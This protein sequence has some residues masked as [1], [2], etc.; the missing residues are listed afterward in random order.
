M[1]YRHTKSVPLFRI[2]DLI[3]IH[4]Y[5]FE[6]EYRYPGES[7]GFW[8]LVY[9]DD[10]MIHADNGKESFF[11]EAGEL[12][13]HAPNTFHIAEGDGTNTSHV[14]I[15]SFTCASP[16][17]EQFRDLRLRVPAR[18]RGLISNIMMEAGAFY[19]M[20]TDGLTPLPQ[21]PKG[22]DQL[23]RLYL[24]QLL[25]LL[26]RQLTM[27][28]NHL[29]V[30]QI[31]GEIIL[32][33]NSRIYGTVDLEQLCEHLHYGKTCLSRLFQ[34]EMGVSIMAYYRSLK[35]KEARRLLRETDDTVAEISAQLCY[36]TPQYFSYAFKREMGITPIQYRSQVCP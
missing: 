30:R 10:G 5:E 17:M 2:Q 11:A 23:I 15:I 20:E 33:L 24:E 29:P 7:H 16:A 22:G 4:Y 21:A 6:P 31:P 35:I 18:L 13:F 36:D 32:Y 9:V 25:I 19:D 3:T 8:E 26:Y 27:Q 14:F 1:G 28:Q 12:L 34:A